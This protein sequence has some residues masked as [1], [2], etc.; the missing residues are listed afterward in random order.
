MS[1]PGAE[2]RPRLLV[3][4]DIGGDP[5]DQQSLIRLMTYANAFRIDGLIASAAG[6]PGELDQ[7]IVRPDLIRQIVDAYGQVQPR[8]ASHAAGYPTVDAVRSV[9]K[10]GNPQRGH[11]R[12]GAKHD[13]E[14]SDWIIHAVD[15]SDQPL[16]IAIWG[17]QT[18]LAQALWRVKR[19]R[20]T[21]EYRDF[22]RKLRIHDIADQDGLFDHLTA[23]HPD[24]R[25]NYV[26]D[27]AQE[28][29][30]CRSVFR[31]MFLGGETRTVTHDWIEQHIQGHGP[32]GEL[33][34]TKTWTC[35]NGVNAIKEGD[36]PSWF[37]FLPHGLNDPAHPDW[38]GWGGRFQWQ[39]SAWR[40][41]MDSV[42]GETSRIA[43]IWRWREAYQHDFQA[44]LDWC[45]KDPADANHPP[46]ARLNGVTG[47]QV[48]TA[49][50]S[51]GQTLHLSAAGSSDPDG[52]G[53][54][55]R[56]FVYPEPGSDP[57][58]AKIEQSDE[59]EARLRVPR[60]SEPQTIHVILAVTDDGD[61]PL[62]SFRR[63][64]ASVTPG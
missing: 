11:D 34:P 19:E 57:G 64:V 53:L 22:I 9:I 32:F 48:V 40:D 39:E 1:P 60:V 38:G 16:C 2:H 47:T 41:A 27:L 28:G 46:L 4:T 59:A 50:V 52:D 21:A 55:C 25:P 43:T 42:D 31:G 20:E 14:A 61:P 15:A 3:T 23:E 58:S 24:L 63:L 33:Y 26:L 45:V 13:T 36:T 5:D 62:R 10:P 8:L 17:G 56:W 54:T 30:S 29:H 7:E 49:E 12:I 35:D 37:Y 6:T 51:A 44:R 18:D